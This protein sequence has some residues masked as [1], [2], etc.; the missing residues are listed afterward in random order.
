MKHLFIIGETMELS[1]LQVFRTVA[2]EGGISA[3]A[4]KLHR[5][6]SNITARIQKLEQEVGTPLFIREKNRLRIS[7]AGTQLLGYA[8]KILALAD[9]AVSELQDTAPSGTLTVSSMESVAATRL[10]DW[11]SEYHHLHPQVELRVQTGPTGQLIQDVIDG[12]IDI[13]LVADPPD[14]RRLL[15][16]PV[17]KETLVMVSHRAHR[18]IRRPTDL[19]E[20]LTLLGFNALCAYRQRLEDWLAQAN[21]A[22]RVVEIGSYHTLLSC[23]AAGMGVGLVTRSLL[24]DFTHKSSLKVHRLPAPW[25]QSTTCLIQRADN[26]RAA[27]TAFRNLLQG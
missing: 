20:P 4:N 18:P 17:L 22:V 8:D 10:A 23:A 2:R 6:P 26:Q 3:A 1:D 12:D 9:Q 11:L 16:V 25:G 24:K 14:D 27:V 21:R 5:V 13:G 7:G 19:E 15:C